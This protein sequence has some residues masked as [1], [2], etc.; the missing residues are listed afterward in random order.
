MT[1]NP[2]VC[3]SAYYVSVLIVMLTVMLTDVAFSFHLGMGEIQFRSLNQTY[4]H[5]IHLHKLLKQY[6]KA[7]LYTHM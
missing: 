1:E 2:N 3:G 4:V 7:L 6:T 5:P